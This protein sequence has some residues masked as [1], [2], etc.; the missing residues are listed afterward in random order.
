MMPN[1]SE[2]ATVSEAAAA[3]RCCQETIRRLVRSGRV[4]ALRV[5]PKIRV[6]LTDVEAALRAHPGVVVPIRPAAEA[7]TT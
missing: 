2:Y 3:V 7:A 4:A 6:R 1:H 5:G